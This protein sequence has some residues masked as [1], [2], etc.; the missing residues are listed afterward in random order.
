MKPQTET[1]NY[2][3]VYKPGNTN[4]ET[5]LLNGQSI[6]SDKTEEQYINAGFLILSW[7][8]VAPLLDAA[9]N[10]QYCSG[11]LHIITEQ[12]FWYALECLPPEAWQTKEDLEMFRM[13]EYYTSN[14]TA[15][16]MHDK[17]TN[18]YYE[19]RRRTPYTHKQAR[20]EIA[21]LSNAE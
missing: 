12:D 15:H 8:Q 2:S 10:K 3:Y 1:T 6:Y 20:E 4:I 7:D 9:E 14:I 5:K 18:T 13:S 21:Q 11:P 19:A 17:L 16:Y